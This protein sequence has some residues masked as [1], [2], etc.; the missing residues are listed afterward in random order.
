MLEKASL[1]IFIQLNSF[2]RSYLF[3]SKSYG[4]QTFCIWQILYPKY[5]LHIRL[6]SHLFGT[7]LK[8]TV[9]ISPVPNFHFA[10]AGCAVTVSATRKIN[11]SAEILSMS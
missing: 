8:L 4:V 11:N 2:Y 3:Y 9:W 6:S 5:L 7:L 10:F 1:Y